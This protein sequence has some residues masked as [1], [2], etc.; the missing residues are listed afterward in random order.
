MRK[1]EYDHVEFCQD[2]VIDTEV[3]NVYGAQGWLAILT[4][5]CMTLGEPWTQIIFM[6]EIPPEQFPS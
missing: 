4:H 1:Y 3:L 5:P 2:R 6:R